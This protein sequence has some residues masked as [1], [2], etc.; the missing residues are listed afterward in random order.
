MRD[1]K[2]RMLTSLNGESKPEDIICPLMS[3]DTLAKIQLFAFCVKG[4]CGAW[5]KKLERCG[6][7]KK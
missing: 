5:N 1:R 7:L 6:L 4:N 3:G 2:R